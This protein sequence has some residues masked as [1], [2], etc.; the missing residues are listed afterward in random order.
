M[1]TVLRSSIFEEMAALAM[2]GV[3]LIP[4]SR[5][6]GYERAVRNR[7]HGAS[8]SI[9]GGSRHGGPHEHRREIARRLRQQARSGPQGER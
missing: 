7:Y 8:G 4:Q 6:Y 5:N 9:A 3:S 1:T 2:L